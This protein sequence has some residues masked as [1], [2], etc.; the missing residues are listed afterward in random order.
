MNELYLII[1]YVLV[2]VSIPC[3]FFRR[4]EGFFKARSPLLLT[5][6]QL[7]GLGTSTATV[8]LMETES[9]LMMAI[10]FSLLLPFAMGP[11]LMMIPGLILKS[12]VNREKINRAKG[13]IAN[14]WKY[15]VLLR[16]DLQFG[17]ICGIAV[18]HLCIFFLFNQYVEIAGN[19]FRLPL[20][21]FN[22]EMII[23]FIPYGILMRNIK[24]VDDP[25]HI[26]IH[27]IISWIITAPITIYT[28]IYP[29]I[30]DLLVDFRYIYIT[31]NIV[32]FLI[33]YFFPLF[34]RPEKRSVNYNKIN[35]ENFDHHYDE[36]LQIA[37]RNWCAEIVLFYEAVQ[38]FKANPTTEKAHLIF[39]TYIEDNSDMWI[40]LSH[41]T[42]ENLNYR[43]VVCPF[44]N[45]SDIFDSAEGE[46]LALINTNLYPLMER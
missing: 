36:L 41:K 6:S 14:I 31:S 23:Y 39:E 35:V 46:V 27:L 34:V 22:A 8:Y 25:Y 11:M 45:M 13:L 20:F 3:W 12:N 15:R 28:I 29:F 44:E 5:L 9:C 18:I 26:R 43:I 32:M 10:F 19:C 24:N 40:N 4:N 2:G 30:P 33:M 38:D 7:Y 37:V 16:T 1:Y 21:L 17:V 42:S